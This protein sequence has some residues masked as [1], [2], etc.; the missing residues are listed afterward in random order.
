MSRILRIFTVTFL[1][2]LTLVLG[3]QI[4]VAMEQRGVRELEENL[5]I[6]YTGQSGSG[7]LMDDPEKNVN[8]AIMWGV[9]RL[10]QKNYITPDRLKTQDMLYGAVGGLVAALGDPYTVFMTPSENDDFHES[11]QGKLEGIGAELTLREGDVIVVAP[12]K[13]SPA[14][15]AGLQP[16][17]IIVKV[18][19]KEVEGQTLAKVVEQIRGPK[20]TSV[21]L[22][23]LRSGEDELLNIDIVRDE[24]KVPSVE[25]EV[26]KTATGSVGYIALNQFGD[27]SVDEVRRA[28]ESFEGEDIAA[29]VFD[30]RYNGGGYLEGAVELSSFFLKDGKV[31][32][33]QRRSG[34][35]VHH[36]VSGHVLEADLPVA[37]LINE[38]SA[39]ASE[40]FAGALQDHKRATIIGK[41]S[42]GKGTVQEVFDLPGGSSIRI[43]TAKWLTPNGRD[44]GSEGI[45][46]DIDIDRTRED[47]EKKR[48]PQLDAAL[49]WLL[50]GED[51]MKK[52]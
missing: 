21:R 14:S 20:G 24:I 35:P 9:W 10:L 41:K 45:I 25:F 40:I 23:I 30:V 3:W 4:G 13:G 39:S 38:G 33:V 42:F 6:L 1:P 19:D 29:L 2:L 46:P 17:D 27:G 22:S 18:N 28:L 48:D 26:K 12:L 44:L 8:P 11:L 15:E 34:D 37:V 50:D 36:Y 31:V 16:E 52:M 49:E 5:R 7:T 47:R 43:T 51:V 32:S